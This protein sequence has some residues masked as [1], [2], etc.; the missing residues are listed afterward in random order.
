MILT[1]TFSKNDK[2]FDKSLYIYDFGLYKGFLKDNTFIIYKILN[3]TM[4]DSK[5][6]EGFATETI[7]HRHQWDILFHVD[8]LRRMYVRN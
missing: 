4:K 1:Y 2:I 6:I 3:K 7:C 8:V 5:L